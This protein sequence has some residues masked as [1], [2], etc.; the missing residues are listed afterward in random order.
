MPL[1]RPHI[2]VVGLGPAGP[3]LVGHN[4]ATL[5]AAAPGRAYLRT[6]RHPAAAQFEGTPAFDALYESAA[7][8]D[9]VYA[10]IVGTLVAAA[11]EAAPQGVVYAVPGSP[12]V[13][14]RTVDLLR[15]DG[16]VEV[17]VLPALSF[18]DLA[19]ACLGVD[20]L[21]AGVRLVDAGAAR[22]VL[23]EQ[24]GPFLVAQCWSRHLLSEVKLAV[25]DE[26]GREMPRP[27]LLHHLGLEDE[28]VVAVD[29]WELDR[30]VEPDHLTSV[31]VP[32]P[33]AAASR[34]VASE[35]ALLVA[36]MDT[37][38]ERCPWDAAQTHAS[39]MPHLV[40]ESYEVL[41]ALGAL[42][43]LGGLGGLAEGE[44]DATAYAHL[45]EE[46]GDLLFQIVFHARLADE[47]GQFDLADVARSVHDK[48]V[49]GHPHVFG[50][51][52]ADTAAQVVTNWEAIKKR[53][54]GRRSVTEGIPAA[55]PALMLTTKL[56]RKARSVGLEADQWSEGQT[57]LTLAALTRRAVEAVPRADDPLAGDAGDV[58]AAGE[59]LYAVALL[60]Q[61]LGVDAEQALRDRALTLRAAILDAE[62]VPEDQVG[63]R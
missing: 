27:V 40:E 49:H 50:D 25:P 43:A 39:L 17:T 60:A 11:V 10:G 63:N 45:Q 4:V 47:A 44:A 30:T 20:P 38:R 41:D 33:A 1:Y 62:G 22:S 21:A 35:M 46:L 55:L 54:K 42:G 28:V 18:L 12:S 24:N 48:L 7:T 14:E 19:W 52:D 57:A 29:W 8:F 16:R 32:A 36:L 58:Q 23:A 53:E 59:L 61:R 34:S 26:D 13:A 2:T 37:L 51:G 6:A 15:A 9:E 3:D 5:V 56:A 31:Y